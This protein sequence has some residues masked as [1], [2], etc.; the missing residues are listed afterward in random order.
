MCP[1]VKSALCRGWAAKWPH[2]RRLMAA[3]SALLMVLTVPCSTEPSSPSP[4][5]APTPVEAAVQDIAFTKARVVD[6]LD[7]VTIDVDIDGQVF[8]VRYLGLD[9]PGADG[10]SVA[11]GALRFNRFLVEGRT[12]EIERGAAEADAAGRLLRY[13]YVGGEMVNMALLTNGY[14]TVASF[15]PDF[16]HR[17]A[18]A[19]AEESAKRERLGIWEA[20]LPETG[21]D[22]GPPSPTQGPP[23]P[24][25]TLPLPPG[26]AGS[27]TVCD[28]SGTAEPVIKANIDPRTGDRIYHVP[29]SFFYS[30][31]VVSEDDG[32][33]WLCTEEEAQ[34]A[35]WKKS[36]HQNGLVLLKPSIMGDSG[37][38][39]EPV[40]GG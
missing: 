24:A 17:T 3:A 36:E 2:E 40:E 14:A 29:G 22:D 38:L 1:Y 21:Q 16:K 23:F 39:G 31:T 13:V 26:T 15:P 9:V 7:G 4:P 18:F 5:P 11:E 12:V 6:V 27:A 32:D 30:T 28:Y 20:T 25:G 8:R 37:P 10:P 35:G 19:V 33:M 34:A